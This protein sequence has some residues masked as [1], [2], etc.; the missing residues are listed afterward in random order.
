MSEVFF[1]KYESIYASIIE[2]TENS[3]ISS[4]SSFMETVSTIPQVFGS[5]KDTYLSKLNSL[6]EIGFFKC[7]ENVFQYQLSDILQIK[8]LKLWDFFFQTANT[9]AEIEILFQND[10]ANKFILFGF[11]LS[12]ED[13]RRSYSTVLKGISMKLSIIDTKLLFY[14]NEIPL[15][16]HSIPFIYF[17]DSVTLSAMRLV[18]LNLCLMKSPEI[19]DSISDKIS[20]GSFD[21]LIASIDADGFAFLNDFI[22]I[23]PLDLSQYIIKRLKRSMNG[24]NSVF[25]CRAVSFLYK[26]RAR[27]MLM[28]HISKNIE[29]FIISDPLSLSMVLFSVQNRMI[30][31]DYAKNSGLIPNQND[32]FHSSIINKLL[33]I[34]KQRDSIISCVIILKILMVLYSSIPDFLMEERSSLIDELKNSFAPSIMKLI[35]FPPDP[36]YRTDIEYF[37]KDDYRDIKYSQEET[38]LLLLAE[39]EKIIGKMSNKAF[40]WF[41]ATPI[42]NLDPLSLP[43]SESLE[44]QITNNELVLSQNKH[45]PIWEIFV[46]PKKKLNK[47]VRIEI[48]THKHKK[49]NNN[50]N[51]MQIIEFDSI[52]M[53]KNFIHEIERRQALI[54]HHY[55]D[56][57]LIK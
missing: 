4:V 54:F 36:S 11:D 10:I 15:F 28:K 49:K 29:K 12:V 42:E 57:L 47:E 27:S 41:Q 16:T 8:L 20:Y 53:A 55:L 52:I 43:V 22:D 26:T 39:L 23:S 18:V 30:I 14:N 9:R 19:Q 31:Y 56:G 32:D 50:T 37:L 40:N 21:N 5:F 33:L 24:S 51:E 25:V 48:G 46:H 1:P 7:M 45:I 3:T 35:V 17:K 6:N 2:M 44:V 38:M 34:L 13:V